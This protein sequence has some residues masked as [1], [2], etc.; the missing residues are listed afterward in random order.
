MT[1][2]R[3]RRD[4]PGDGRLTTLRYEGRGQGGSHSSLSPT[5][6]KGAAAAGVESSVSVYPHPSQFCPGA[7][8][9]LSKWR[10]NAH[11]NN[12]WSIVERQWG[13][14]DALMRLDFSFAEILVVAELRAGSDV[15][16]PDGA[17]AA[18][19]PDRGAAGDGPGAAAGA[20]VQ[21]VLRAA[22]Q[23][24]RVFQ[25]RRPDV[26]DL[27]QRRAGGQA[28]VA[29]GGLEQPAGSGQVRGGAH[30]AGGD[31]SGA[32]AARWSTSP[33]TRPKRPAT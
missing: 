21:P 29:R 33:R 32:G 16:T 26:R 14:D 31:V 12:C 17:R 1:R 2:R 3:L 19:V 13:M 22:A 25:Q 11:N 6:G 18:G 7:G 15:G 30:A 24:L 8:A 4:R 20:I 9:L 5:F 27:R 23:G 28:G 10:G